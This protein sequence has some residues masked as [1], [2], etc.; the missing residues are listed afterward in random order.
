MAGRPIDSDSVALWVVWITVWGDSVLTAA[1]RLLTLNG[2]GN[3]KEEV[4]LEE[5]GM[6]LIG[7]PR[8]M[9]PFSKCA[10]AEIVS[11]SGLA[12]VGNSWWSPWLLGITMTEVLSP[13][14][15]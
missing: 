15:S 9:P 3:V 10:G 7:L 5:E 8:R 4:V 12:L 1:F 6:R 2:G 13:E 14:G 11:F